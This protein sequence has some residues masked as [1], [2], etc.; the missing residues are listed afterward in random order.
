MPSKYSVP[1]DLKV[2]LSSVKSEI[3]DPRNRNQIKC[4]LPG[5]E[6]HALQELQRM[7]KERQIIVKACDKGAGIIILNFNV[8]LQVYYEHLTSNKKIN[9]HIIPRLVTG[10]LRKPSEK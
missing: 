9:S 1:E 8:Y 7:K 10:I 6:L 5:S 3:L 2:F 4:N